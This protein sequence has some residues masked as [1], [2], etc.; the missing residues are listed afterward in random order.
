MKALLERVM[1]TYT[2]IYRENRVLSEVTDRGLAFKHRNRD[3]N[4]RVGPNESGNFTEKMRYFLGLLRR[5]LYFIKVL[6][7][8]Y[9]C[10]CA[11]Q[12]F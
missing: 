7:D 11:P 9:N 1:Y 10:F 3:E 4:A 12:D 2:R 5:L 8:F 6:V